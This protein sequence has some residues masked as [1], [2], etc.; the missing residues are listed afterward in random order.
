MSSDS[1]TETE[2][3]PSGLQD[4]IKH[5]EAVAFVPPKQRYTDAGQLAKT[6]AT[7]AYESGIPPP[8]LERLLKLLTTH[9]AL[10]QGTVTTLVKNLY[11]VERISSKII[12]Q[13]VCCLG[14]AKTKPSAATQALLV[15]WLILV[16]DFIDDG[17]HLSK[18]YAV[19]FNYLDMISL[20]KPLCHLLS[21]ITR[22]KHVKPFRIQALMELVSVSGGEEKEL[23]ILLNVF[24]NYCPDVIVGDLGLSGRKAAFFKHPDPEW[25]AHVREI[26]DTHLERLQAVEPS[27]FQVVHRGLAKRSKIQVI[28]PD[29]KTSRVSYNHTSLEELRGVEHLVEK[30][31]KIELP[32]QII[33][34]LGNS[35]AQKY[36]FLVRSEA[37]NR[38]LNDWLRTFLSDQLECAWANDME[39]LESLGYILALAVEYVQ[40]TKEIPDAFT[41]FLRKYL[42][43]WNG[44]DNKEQILGLLQHLPVQD[45]DTLR[46]DFLIP[47]ESAIL[48][49]ALSSRT[50]LLDSYSSL[51]RRWGIHLRVQPLVVEESKPLGRLIA[52][53]E[54]LAL[55]TLEC[56]TPMRQ[57]PG[58]RSERYKPATL[59]ITE[60]YCTLAEL[61]S[62]ASMNGS[63]RLTVPLAPTV[64]TLAFTPISSVISI[65]SSVL[66]SYKSS[67]ESSLTSHVLQVPSSQDSLYPTGL[68]G[69]FNGYIMDVCNLL[70]RNRGLNSEDPNALGCL[71]PP[72]TIGA[73][74]RYIRETNERERKRETAFSYTISSIFSLSHHIALCNMSAACFSDIE[75]END[76][77]EDRPKLKKPVTQKALSAL[78]KEGGMKMTWQEY[79]VRML[80]WLDATGTVGIGNLM[81]STMKAL[82][83]E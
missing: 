81:R 76:I 40:Y 15:R 19:L 78:E 22:R 61:F 52:H 39:D 70:W 73:L 36:L 59:S 9:N 27:T 31:D 29:V 25:T 77:G 49:A 4:A 38:R 30:V 5:L 13:V 75:D 8:A 54:L 82:R 16:Y 26:Q 50:S 62:H 2:V 60:F 80:D 47:L 72:A 7:G 53:A 24:K 12:T 18:L 67:F 74:T 20:R 42:I 33:S 1:E 64:Y 57:P 28:V 56:L 83:K 51:I 34:M 10:D 23:L 55:S 6:I 45:F 41:S 11:P 79:R 37:A 17:S 58:G 68:V 44:E 46:K 43:S 65:M 35:L 48:T 71:I 32:N 14:P 69:Q 66:A 63:I 3:R 21:I